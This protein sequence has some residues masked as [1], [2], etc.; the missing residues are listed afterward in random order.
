[1]HQKAT[2]G[3]APSNSIQHVVIFVKENHTFDNYFGT[4]PGANGVRLPPAPDPVHDPPHNHQAWLD[5]AKGAVHLQYGQQDIPS[6][7]TRA[8]IHPL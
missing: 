1:M 8:A 4:F 5:R 3:T 2:V 6:L 7:G